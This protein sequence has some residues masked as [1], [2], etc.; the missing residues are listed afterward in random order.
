MA[1]EKKP[2]NYDELEEIVEYSIGLEDRI[3]TAFDEEITEEY[4]TGVGTSYKYPSGLLMFVSDVFSVNINQG[5]SGGSYYRRHGITYPLAFKPGTVPMITVKTILSAFNPNN[6]TKWFEE[7][8]YN[9]TAP[10]KA[11]ITFIHDTSI[12]NNYQIAVF[13]RWK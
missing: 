10:T 1:F 6:L 2:L 11:T 9:A 7:S 12:T 13:G 8:A 3:E 5:P 4:T